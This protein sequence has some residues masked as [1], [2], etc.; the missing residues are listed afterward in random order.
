MFSNFVISQ[1]LKENFSI[2]GHIE[3]SYKG[4]L[5]LNYNGKQDSCLVENNKFQF[6]GNISSE[7][8]YA[9]KFSTS[10]T[11][12]M[13]SNLFLENKDI[14][15]IIEIENRKYNQT[16]YDWIILKS[17]LGTKTSLIAFNYNQFKVKNKNKLNWETLNYRKIDSI[18][19]E[20]PKN[21]YSVELLYNIATDSLANVEEIRMM[22]KKLDPI[23]NDSQILRNLKE[24]I[25][26]QKKIF[27]G[28]LL[29]YF[30]LK[31]Q[32]NEMINLDYYQGNFLLID[33]WAS[34][35][36]PCI[37]QIP[38]LSNLQNKYNNTNFK[39]LSISIDTDYKKWL[40]TIIKQEM[41]WDNVIDIDGEYSNEINIKS[42][43]KTF[44][45]N[46][47]GEIVG[48]DMNNEE[49]EKILEKIEKNKL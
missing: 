32:N 39:I 44:L 2:V 15:V 38:K 18:I 49:I 47:K 35:C 36:G 33:F 28:E 20:N 19:M 12:A 46:P 4:Y 29:P 17:V 16:D 10:R 6:K 42:I 34:W 11:S 13:D 30:N 45:I 27:L 40:D 21:Q 43:P 9:C 37:K 7:I 8:I 25:Y 14:K 1:D 22:Y 5:Y 26:P 23:L 24:I 48:I 31:N 41:K 3:G